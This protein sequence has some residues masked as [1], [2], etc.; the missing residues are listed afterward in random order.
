MSAAT[1]EAQPVLLGAANPWNALRYGAPAAPEGAT[2]GFALFPSAA[3][4]DGVE[5]MPVFVVAI[6]D[7]I[8]AALVREKTRVRDHYL[9]LARVC[10]ETT[11]AKKRAAYVEALEAKARMRRDDE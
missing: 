5:V 6:F 4:A 1:V 2:E 8:G 11:L 9:P 10:S 7:A 3:C